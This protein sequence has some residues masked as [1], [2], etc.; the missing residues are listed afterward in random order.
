MKSFY[1]YWQSLRPLLNKREWF[2]YYTLTMFTVVFSVLLH[3]TGFFS[4]DNF[5]NIVR[6]TAP[7]ILMALGLSFVLSVRHID[8]S[9]GAV[10]ALSAVI[11]ALLLREF[12]VVFA[13]FSALLTGIVIGVI[14]G[15]IV[16]YLKVSALLVTLGT[17]SIMVGITRA[18]S[19]LA[20]I[21]IVD[22]TFLTLF[23]AGNVFDVPISVLWVLLI[24]IIVWG[25]LEYFAFGRYLIAVAKSPRV[26]KRL[27]ISTSK[28]RMSAFVICSILAA[29]AGL[30]YAGRMQ[31]ARYTLGESDL[32]NVF[33]AVAIGSTSLLG[34]R[35]RVIGIA[36]GAVLMGL[37]NNG[38]ILLGFSVNAQLIAKGA[39]LVLAITLVHREWYHAQ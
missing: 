22:K 33:V 13:V 9:I 26:A 23:G 39:V 10:V 30:L 12:N 16:V 5:T 28:V 6:Q 21:P 14:N 31:G 8:L 36:C 20:S 37:L 4:F 38:L 27:C 3:D 7:V 15:C 32:L 11:A 1:P 18:I 25:G 17:M 19:E 29:F 34:S 24:I 35:I 2:V